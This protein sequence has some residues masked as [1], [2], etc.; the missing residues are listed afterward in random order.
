VAAQ[1]NGSVL[2]AESSVQSSGTTDTDVYAGGIQ[3][4]IAG[5]KIAAVNVS[6]TFQRL[7]IPTP[8][9]ELSVTEGGSSLPAQSATL[10][11]TTTENVVLTAL[12]PTKLDDGIW[13]PETVTSADVQIKRI[14]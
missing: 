6:A 1:G 11:G 4:P 8:T 9:V 2:Y 3:P 10:T 7:G 13:T 14:S 5:F 12:Y